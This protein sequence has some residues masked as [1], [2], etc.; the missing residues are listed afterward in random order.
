MQTV[1][2]TVSSPKHGLEGTYTYHEPET[3][4]EVF[5]AAT[6]IGKGLVTFRLDEN[7][8]VVATFH[9]ENAFRTVADYVRR[10]YDIACDHAARNAMIAEAT[11]NEK[12]SRSRL[13][14]LL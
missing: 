5:E 10:S 9:S 4:A 11:G 14:A 6:G 2:R 8:N 12:K 7:G 1:K 3:C 13:A